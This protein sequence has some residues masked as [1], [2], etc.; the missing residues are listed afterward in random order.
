[1]YV[2][3][4]FC[5]ESQD[6]APNDGRVEKFRLWADLD[7]RIEALSKHQAKM[8]QELHELRKQ[9]TSLGRTLVEIIEPSDKKVTA[10]PSEG[11]GW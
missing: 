2:D 3:N 5:D 11:A 4:T 6:V 10:E 7:N 9:R 8:N 1:M